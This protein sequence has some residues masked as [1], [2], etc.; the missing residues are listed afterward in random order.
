MFLS[1]C[2]RLQAA[3]ALNSDLG[4]RFE[5]NRNTVFVFQPRSNKTSSRRNSICKIPLL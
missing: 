2:D 5:M 1:I 4:K 3:N